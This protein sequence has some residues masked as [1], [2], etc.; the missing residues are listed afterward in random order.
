MAQA[1]CIG[2]IRLVLIEQ[3]G[4]VVG[5]CWVADGDRGQD[6]YADGICYLVA[7][8]QPPVAAVDREQDDGAD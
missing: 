6:G 4:P 5:V 8:P 2:G 1:P 3:A 7:L